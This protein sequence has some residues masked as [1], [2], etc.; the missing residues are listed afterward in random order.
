MIVYFLSG[1]LW[2]AGG[3][4]L[5]T[6]MSIYAEME[7]PSNF[8]ALE[9]LLFGDYYG[10]YLSFEDWLLFGVRRTIVM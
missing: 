4:I 1:A 8:R 3:P 10:R 9:L 5:A 7:I 2:V 6:G